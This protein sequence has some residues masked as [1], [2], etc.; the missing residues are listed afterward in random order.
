MAGGRTYEFRRASMW[1]NQQELLADG[2][3]AG[4]LRRTGAWSGDVEADLPGMPLPVQI[5][6]VGVQIAIW[7][8]QQTA[9][10]G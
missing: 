6:V 2:V 3:K 8:A 9:A 10:A 4:S 5:C 1:G 7:Q